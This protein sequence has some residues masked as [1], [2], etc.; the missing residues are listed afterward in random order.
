MLHLPEIDRFVDSTTG[1]MRIEAHTAAI[2]EGE[3]VFKSFLG[4]AHYIKIGNVNRNNHPRL[5]GTILHEMGTTLNSGYIEDIII[6]MTYLSYLRKVGHRMQ[7]GIWVNCIIPFNDCYL[8]PLRM[9]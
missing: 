2:Q 1:G 9:I 3:G 4:N 6:I 8:Y 7:V 5:M